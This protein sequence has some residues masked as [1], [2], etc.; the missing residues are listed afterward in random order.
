[1]P[2]TRSARWCGWAWRRSNR[3]RCN[4]GKASSPSTT[5]LESS[6]WAVTSARR[7]PRSSVPTWKEGDDKW[8]Y[9][10]DASVDLATHKVSLDPY[11]LQSRLIL[12]TIKE[13]LPA[14]PLQRVEKASIDEV[15]LD[16]SSHVHA[17]LLERHPELRGP[18]P[19]DDPSE[20]LPRPPTTALDWDTDALVDLDRS[21]SEDDDPDWD[22]VA[23][24]I[25]SEIVRGVRASVRE[26]L[27][28]TCSAG[29]A[30][31]KMLA[32]LGSAH[33]KPN[34]QTIVRN[35]AAQQFLSGLK[36]TKI[37]TLGGKLGDTIVSVFGTDT[38]GGLL[39]VPVEQ[40]K[41]RLGDG[42]GIWVHQI[43]RGVDSSEVSART[44]IQSMLSA[45]SFRPMISSV[46]QAVRWLR[47]FVA[48]IFSRLVEEGVLEKRRR[49]KTMNLHHRHAGQMRSRQ[50]P[51][52]QGRN[53]DETVLF[54]LAKSLLGQIIGE[55]SVWP[56]ANL[57]LSV[58][59]FEDAVAGNRG[60]SAF[61]VKG[62]DASAT[63]AGSHG[64]G[65]EHHPVDQSGSDK[66]RR[67]DESGIQKFF[68]RNDSS[69]EEPEADA[70]PPRAR[71]QLLERPPSLQ[72][73]I[74]PFLCERCHRSITLEHR[75]EHDDWH[76]AK[77]LQTQDDGLASSID[78]VAEAKA[79]KM[80]G[81][82]KKTSTAGKGQRKLA[83]GQ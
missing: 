39:A 82:S 33:R 2:S 79:G 32:K 12:A 49:P 70:E 6:G 43:I 11:R 71:E 83:F 46:D 45:K 10:E 69:V 66:R 7:R 65:D 36:F 26:K 30:R 24:L 51:I 18:A 15:F 78:G 73:S 67:I 47:I 31:N 38:V 54:D 59:G 20:S 9:R 23:M 75:H 22:D 3:W 58:G 34:Q 5:R 44:Q 61:L 74:S 8:A 76:F 42:T 4:N 35:R 40:L 55:G 25:G 81:R 14:P 29:I 64:H 72:R 27:K 57:S 77:D 41:Q 21:E 50:A 17:I 19:Y 60:I 13:A 62:G 28:Y 68:V 37:R 53:M 48:D 1:M 63:H 56:C 80:V 52:P 16:L